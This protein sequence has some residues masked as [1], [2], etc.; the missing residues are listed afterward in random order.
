MSLSSWSG[1]CRPDGWARPA[2]RA[3]PCCHVS[4][5]LNTGSP[6]HTL[7]VGGRSALPDGHSAGG[8]QPSDSPALGRCVGGTGAAAAHPEP[9]TAPAT[10]GPVGT[11]E[12]RGILAS[13]CPGPADPMDSLTPALLMTPLAPGLHPPTT[14]WLGLLHKG[15]RNSCCRMEE[16]GSVARGWAGERATV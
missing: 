11:A 12:F 8:A 5:R 3:C 4:V 14:H 6:V 1:H 16:M 10:A 2:V 9:R 13:F 7:Q 15:P